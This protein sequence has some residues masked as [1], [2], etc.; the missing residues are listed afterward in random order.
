[1]FCFIFTELLADLASRSLPDDYR[2]QYMFTSRSVD[3][4]VVRGHGESK[5]C[6]HLSS[7]RI[8]VDVQWASWHMQGFIAPR[9]EHSGAV[10]RVPLRILDRRY[11]FLF[12]CYIQVL[13][14]F[15]PLVFSLTRSSSKP[16]SQCE[17]NHLPKTKESFGQSPSLSSHSSLRRLRLEIRAVHWRQSDA[18]ILV[19]ASTLR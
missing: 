9:H 3:G 6:G 17:L 14:H 2:Q 8:G 19:P 18:T 11:R 16:S 5:D 12:L 15:F 7:Y 13:L 4:S 1:M 10:S